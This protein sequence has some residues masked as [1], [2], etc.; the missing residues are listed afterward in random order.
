MVDQ[1]MIKESALV[2][3]GSVVTGWTLSKVSHSVGFFPPSLVTW[4]LVGFGG[5]LAAEAAKSQPRLSGFFGDAAVVDQYQAHIS[6]LKRVIAS[7]SPEGQREARKKLAEAESHLRQ[8]QRQ[9][10]DS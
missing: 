2:G 10:Q 9:L 4:F 7:G 3:L 6:D 1:K 5:N 8:W